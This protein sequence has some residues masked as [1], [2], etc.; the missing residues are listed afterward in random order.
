M[1]PGTTSR[2]DSSA[3]QIADRPAFRRP[4]VVAL[5][6]GLSALAMLVAV[7]AIATA[8]DLG[9][10]AAGTASAASPSPSP[11]AAPTPVWRL[12]S[13]R[14]VGF[15][16]TFKA[17]LA[18]GLPAP[19]ELVVFGGSRAMRFEASSLTARTGLSAF[20]CAVQC[21]RPEDAWA[22]SSYLYQRAPD[23]RLRCVIALQARTFT[24]DQMRAGLL[25]DPRLSSAFPDDLV[26]RQKKS[27]GTPEM[28]QVLGENRYSERGYLVRNRYDITR[29]RSS[30]RFARH[31]DISI[32]RLLPN[33]TWNGPPREAR[34]RAYFEKTVTLYNEHGVTPLV[35]LM[36]VQP[37]ALRA[38]RAVGFQRHLD[39]L[40]TYLASA[41]TRCRFRVLDF[42]KIRSFGGSA[43]AFYDA[44]H[45]TRE[46]TRRL[47]ARA[48]ELAP[49]CFE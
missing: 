13:Y 29:E 35:V 33:H 49:E 23:T 17:D 5:A 44:V 48:V 39:G 20:N 32:A 38:F 15:D 10:A 34:A 27:L 45:P 16:K 4:A 6:A 1:T 19:P 30:Y 36:P 21:F 41:Q 11:S 18:M 26:A 31:I 42:T 25:Y 8:G 28:K 37:R 43:T 22:F 2:R 12:K 14:R 7:A 46:N 3:R 47:I 9:G 40:T 24:D